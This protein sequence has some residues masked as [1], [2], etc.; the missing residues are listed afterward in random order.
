[1]KDSQSSSNTA[2]SLRR[3][4]HFFWKNQM[5]VTT[6]CNSTFSEWRLQRQWNSQ[7]RMGMICQRGTTIT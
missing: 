7:Q 4:L 6:I 1:M 2:L 5:L 3:I